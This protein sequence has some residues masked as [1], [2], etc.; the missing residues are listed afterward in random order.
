MTF[1]FYSKG[2]L[3]IPM[4]YFHRYLRLTPALAAAILMYVSLL[5]R[6]ADGPLA[7]A[8][9]GDSANCD[10]Y[11]WSALL[12]VQNYVN[13]ENVVSKDKTASSIIP[14]LS[15]FLLGAVSRSLVVLVGRHA[16]IYFIAVDCVANVA[17]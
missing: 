2:R 3:N 16:T 6:A 17:I 1:L 10:D 9:T 12:Y 5:K 14:R 13:R 11:W 8:L 7:V 15:H 4:L